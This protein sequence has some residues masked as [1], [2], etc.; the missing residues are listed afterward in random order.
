MMKLSNMLKV[1]QTLDQNWQSPLTEMMLSRWGFDHASAFYIRS[2]A[3]HIFLVKNESERYILRFIAVEERSESELVG[4]IKLLKYLSQQDLKVNLPLQSK[5]GLEVEKV[6][7]ELGQYFVSI[8]TYIEGEHP[9]IAKLKQEDFYNWGSALGQLHQCLKKVPANISAMRTSWRDKLLFIQEA[10]QNE[11]LR[12]EL[13][14]LL[15]YR[16]QLPL[17]PESY[18]LI[19]YDFEL[20]NL[21]WQNSYIGIIDFD[22]AIHHW[23]VA[24]IAYALRDL[25]KDGIDLQNPSFKQFIV[26]YMSQTNLDATLLEHL[27]W[28]MR[29]HRVN[30]Y[31]RIKSAVDIE[32]NSDHPEWLTR[33]RKKLVDRNDTYITSLNYKHMLPFEGV[34]ND[35]NN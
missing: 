13:D 4:E 26:G 35:E 1:V 2:S 20:D 28:A 6:E 25:Y 30:M 19:H 31:A 18:G 7:T 29:V 12:E 5:Q 15:A 16:E 14:Q 22:D 11:G 24:D 33:L 8:F 10:D 23:Y 21:K 34:I 9:E 32:A 27:D 17:T 3:N